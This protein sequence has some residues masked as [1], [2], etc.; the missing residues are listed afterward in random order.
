MSCPFLSK[1][2]TSFLTSYAT[3]LRPYSAKC[4]VMSTGAFRS[5][6]SSADNWN[7]PGESSC[8]RPNKDDLS[9]R[10][11]GAGETDASHCPF[12]ETVK[13][14][15]TA[16]QDEEVTHEQQEERGSG[17]EFA[18]DAFPY[19]NF[20]QEQILK[21]KRDHSYRIFKKVARFAKQ[22]PFAQNFASLDQEITVWC[23]NDYLG[24]TAHPAVRAAVM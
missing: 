14:T 9:G 8:R 23:S 18:D 16:V 1:L 5:Y 13:P 15:I 20:F 4:P 19:Q 2:P 10:E 17:T 21:K 7:R 3:L 24:M 11:H 6:S 12:L 22:P